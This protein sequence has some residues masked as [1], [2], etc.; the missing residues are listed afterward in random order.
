VCLFH[1]VYTYLAHWV[2]VNCSTKAQKIYKSTTY[3]QFQ[4]QPVMY[5][6]ASL[7]HM[8]PA[9][10][11]ADGTNP[12]VKDTADGTNPPAK[13]NGANPPPKGNDANPPPKGNAANPPTKSTG[14]AD[15]TNPTTVLPPRR[16]VLCD[17]HNGIYLTVTV[18]EMKTSVYRAILRCLIIGITILLFVIFW[19]VCDTCILATTITA[20]VLPCLGLDFVQPMCTAGI[21]ACLYRGFT[22]ASSIAEIHVQF[23]V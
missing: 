5:V 6:S 17:P 12:P 3:I 23:K 4:Y 18:D 8:N 22:V 7:V 13:G 10:R 11:S 15:V 9:Q 1:R 16:A 2:E 21:V 20:C 14:P 19:D